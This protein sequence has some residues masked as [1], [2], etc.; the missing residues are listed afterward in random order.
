MLLVTVS[1]LL[2]D[3]RDYSSPTV[4]NTR[5]T[6]TAV[7]INYWQKILQMRAVYRLY[8]Q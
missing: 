4:G 1:S 5:G 2:V 8:V 7:G 3:K 6:F